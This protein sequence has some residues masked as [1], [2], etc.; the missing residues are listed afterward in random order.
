MRHRFAIWAVANLHFNGDLSEPTLDEVYQQTYA[1]LEEGGLPGD[2]CLDGF[3]Y[4][5][6]VATLYIYQAKWPDKSSKTTSIG[7]AHEVANALTI[8]LADIDDRGPLPEV[9]EHVVKALKDVIRKRGKIILRGVTGGRWASTQADRIRKLLPKEIGPLMSLELLGINELRRLL[10]ERTED[11]SGK[12][13]EF[14]LLQET[15]DPILDHPI[16]G[17]P[18]MSDAIVTLMSALSLAA[19]AKSW[20]QQ[21]FEKNVR[22]YLGRGR[23][24]KDMEETILSEEGRKS[25]WYGHNGITL[26]CDEFKR[27]GPKNV[28]K[29]IL[30]T[31]PQ[32]VNGCQTA[33][34]LAKCFGQ[35]RQR[36][37]VEDFAVLGRVIKLKGSNEERAS[38]AELIAFRTNSQSAVNDADLRANDPHQRHLQSA[39]EKY[40]EGWFYERKRGEWKNLPRFKKKKFRT[41]DS[42]DRVIERDPYQQAWRAYTGEPSQ[43]LTQKNTVWERTSGGKDLYEQVF[44]MDRR[45]CDVVIASTLFDWFAQVFTV[46]R[47]EKSSLCFDIH[48]GLE[49]H[50]DI[51]P[52]AKMLIASHSVALVGAVIHQAF[53]SVENYPE[54]HV[55]QVISNLHRGRHV[56]RSWKTKPKSWAVL[57]DLIERIMETWA[58]YIMGI[59]KHEEVLHARLKQPNA[60]GDLKE[61]FRGLLKGSIK[62]LAIPKK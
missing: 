40:G 61:T 43:A 22:L 52:K 51:L 36:D 46:R 31:N 56:R 16:S 45:P 60:F 5:E 14:A 18:G 47:K 57:E 55:H 59:K 25:F 50:V 29:A 48:R 6:D 19:N 11:L 37:K 58:F 1:L 27:V 38:A 34:T 20:G 24:N 2:S 3:F 35:E 15:Q 54:K 17:V 10:S 41:K 33:T 53:G 13:I 39:L 49:I 30:L 4:E 7:D 44:S 42:A 21:L 28:P 23:V 9:R 8:L 32:I 12:E 26:L 62:E